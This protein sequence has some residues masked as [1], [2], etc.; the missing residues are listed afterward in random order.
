MFLFVDGKY[1][2]EERA[3][4]SDPALKPFRLRKTDLQPGEQ[5]TGTVVFDVPAEQA[6]HLSSQGSNLILVNYSDRGK[7]FPVGTEPL[8]ALG[9]IRLWK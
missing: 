8:E 3:A 9:Y 7:R 5:A 6:G 2:G 4:E 1:F